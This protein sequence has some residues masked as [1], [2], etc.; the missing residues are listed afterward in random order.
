MQKGFRHRA[1]HCS[2]NIR[3]LLDDFC[4]TNSTTNTTILSIKTFQL[5]VSKG[6]ENNDYFVQLVWW[7]FTAQ[8]RSI[9]GK[10][11]TLV[12]K[13][14]LNKTISKENKTLIQF[15]NDPR[16]NRGKPN[17]ESHEMKTGRRQNGNIQ[18]QGWNRRENNRQRK[19]SHHSGK[20]L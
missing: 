3:Y 11:E 10:P 20:L 6:F 14:W 18:V 5:I 8:R 16:K 4:T 1:N 19:T 2:Y 13:W 17:H 7:D 12:E 15:R 9:R